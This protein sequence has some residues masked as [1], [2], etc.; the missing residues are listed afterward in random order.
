M[1]QCAWCPWG[2]L[3]EHSQTSTS[4]FLEQTLIDAIVCVL[5]NCLCLMEEGASF[6]PRYNG[7]FLQFKSAT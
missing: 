2:S 5:Y 6:V 3:S 4:P 1:C 7:V